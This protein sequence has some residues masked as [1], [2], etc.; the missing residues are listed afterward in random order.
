MKT[1]LFIQSYQ[2]TTGLLGAPTFEIHL[3]V[4][5]PQ[6][7]ITGQ[8]I[9]SNVS[10]HPAMEIYTKLNGEFTYMTVMPNNTSILVNATGYP[11]VNF[12]PHA[13]IGP[14]ILPNTKLTMV[15]E[16]NWLTGTANYSYVDEQ[17]NWNEIQNAKV[18]AIVIPELINNN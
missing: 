11:N 2:I 17:G 15:L 4:N 13:G 6:Q 9:V 10:I 5:T 3:A 18:T 7:N 16:S 12:P 8:G 14:V 1:G